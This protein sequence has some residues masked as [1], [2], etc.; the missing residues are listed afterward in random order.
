MEQHP[1]QDLSSNTFMVSGATVCLTDFN[2]PILLV[3]IHISSF[4]LDSWKTSPS[5]VVVV[6][7]VTTLSTLGSMDMAAMEW[8]VQSTHPPLV[9]WRIG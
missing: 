8:Q 7:V 5:L 2:F 3:H 6:A 4:L 9:E 1:L